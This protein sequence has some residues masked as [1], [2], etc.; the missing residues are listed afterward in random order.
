[1]KKSTLLAIVV[2]LGLTAAACGSGSEPS[3]ESTA[4]GDTSAAEET[5]TTT[6]AGDDD[7][8]TTEAGSDGTA[9]EAT[10]GSLIETATTDLGE[11]LV[12]DKGLTVYGFTS[13]VDG[14]PTCTGSCADAWPA[15]LVEGD[16]LPEGLDPSVFSLVES[17]GGTNQLKAGDW[18]LYYFASDTPGDTSGQG[19]GDVWFVVSPTGALIEE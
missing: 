3:D 8:E 17:P 11:I 12:D 10:G 14:T 1:M 19:V 2:V 16:T 7:T 9:A 6:A 15:V 4:T 18:P 13:D 5:D